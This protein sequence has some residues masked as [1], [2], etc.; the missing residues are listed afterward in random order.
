MAAEAMAAH[1]MEYAVFKQ[2][3]ANGNGTL[4]REEVQAALEKLG[5][6][7][8]SGVLMEKLDTNQDGVVTFEEFLEGFRQFAETQALTRAAFG[9]EMDLLGQDVYLSVTSAKPGSEAEFARLV[10]GEASEFRSRYCDESKTVLAWTD[11][12]LV[13]ML[14]YSVDLGR[15]TSSPA[16]ECGFD[17]AKSPALFRIE[18]DEESAAKAEAMLGSAK[19]KF[20]T[21]IQ[22][23]TTFEGLSDYATVYRFQ[24]KNKELLIATSKK[25]SALRELYTDESKYL[26]FVADDVAIEIL[27]D[28]KP[29][30]LDLE[31]SDA[32][33]KEILGDD[34][35]LEDFCESIVAFRCEKHEWRQ[36]FPE[37]GML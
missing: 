6:E 23:G 28:C 25:L 13:A 12:G 3:D 18:G 27:H 34:P 9:F 21:L 31:V 20:W 15:A 7:G 8:L 29:E 10:G 4:E 30:G 2:I 26:L 5:E 19:T 32:K 33:Y 16:G 24:P 22:S 35:K 1:P 14:N 37:L 17:L 36:N 11:S